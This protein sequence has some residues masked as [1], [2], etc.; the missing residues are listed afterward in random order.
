MRTATIRV[1]FEAATRRFPMAR[2][3]P[4]HAR[5]R[6]L[7]AIV[8]TASV[9]AATAAAVTAAVPSAPAATAASAALPPT[10]VTAPDPAGG[11]IEVTPHRAEPG[12]EVRV[13]VGFCRAER[14]ALATSVA[15]E[16]DIELQ[17]TQDGAAFHGFARISGDA[18]P[19]TYGL[20][21]VCG[22]DAREGQGSFRVVPAGGGAHAGGR[23]DER[24]PSGER[25]HEPSG[26]HA[27][28]RV[29]AGGGGTAAEPPADG[30]QAAQ[31]IGLTMA[32][33][34]AVAGA[35]VWVVRR[36]RTGAH[37]GG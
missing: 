15:F 34:A 14:T 29:R 5:R 26:R 1:I 37:A 20:T 2:T 13:R 3:P 31:R 4:A 8:R 36:R 28:P 19:G 9:T 32:G 33:G 6:S 18:E 10:A 27:S 17:R 12:T 25:H 16:A 23:H 22:A 21:V 11:Q 35:V 24:R 7:S 30:T